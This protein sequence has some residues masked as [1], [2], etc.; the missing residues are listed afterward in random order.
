MHKR[1]KTFGTNQLADREDIVKN[2]LK[3]IGIVVVL[4]SGTI[5]LSN[6]L[7]QNSSNGA[8]MELLRDEISILKNENAKLN[9]SVT[10]MEVRIKRERVLRKLAI[11]KSDEEL[12]EYME[13]R[14]LTLRGVVCATIRLESYIRALPIYSEITCFVKEYDSENNVLVIDKFEWI[15]PEDYE[16]IEEL[17]LDKEFSFSGSGRYLHN[18]EVKLEN[19]YVPEDASFYILYEHNSKYVTEDFFV[20]GFN[21]RLSLFTIKLIGNKIVEVT[22]I[23][24]P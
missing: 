7:V 12:K 10:E 24:V 9:E 21:E 8:E 5:L 22:E 17:G 13:E 11:E 23:F 1:S 19:Y 4:V 3:K 6:L 2:N 16:K 15:Y 14:F 20:K 18:E